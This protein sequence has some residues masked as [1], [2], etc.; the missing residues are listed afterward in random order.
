MRAALG[1]SRRQLLRQ[2][3]TEYAMLA[4]AGVAGAVG[5][6]NGSLRWCRR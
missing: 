2:L 3:I 6:A 5:L 1:A 4:A